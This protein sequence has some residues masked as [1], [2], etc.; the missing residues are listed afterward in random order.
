MGKSIDDVELPSWADSPYDFISKLR[1]ALEGPYVSSHL[2]EWID[3]TFGLKTLATVRITCD[4]E[5]NPFC[6]ESLER[7]SSKAYSTNVKFQI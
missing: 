3:I 6:Y 4:N 2:H 5:Y 1:Q 7:Q